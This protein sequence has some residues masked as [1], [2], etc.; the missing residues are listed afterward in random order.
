MGVLKRGRAIRRGAIA[1]LAVVFM[2]VLL[3][4]T[5]CSV[6]LTW[7]ILTQS[8]LRNVADAAALAGAN[9]LID[10]HVLYHLPNQTSAQKDALLKAA[11]AEARA[12]AKLYT[13]F[14]G[15]GDK[16]TLTLRDE[17][18]EFGYL[19]RANKYT[20]LPNYTGYPNTITV[21]IRRDSNA[22][23]PL[24]LYFAR[25]FARS[26]IELAAESAA[27]IYTG[28]LDSFK[29]TSLTSIGALPVTY[30]V[31]HWDNFLATGLDPDGN[32]QL[33]ADGNPQLQVYP[34][35]KYKGNFGLISL[36]DNHIGAS[37]VRTWIDFGMSPTDVQSLI[38]HQL[39][40]L[41]AH[42]K[43]A[44]DWNGE[45]GFKAANVMDVNIYIGKSF[46][47]PL[48]E[49]KNA[50]ANSYEAGVGQ[51]SNYDFDIVAFVGITIMQPKNTNREVVVQPAAIVEPD[52]VFLTGTVMP[53]Q[54]PDKTSKLVTTFTTP[55]LS[56]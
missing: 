12:A 56:R 53:A 35:I 50:N 52:A 43:N 55:K 54:P 9:K 25:V 34:S 24:D 11:Q 8:E 14:N 28:S 49:P 17:D 3:A 5:A 13:S 36:D 41:S 48:Y 51:G 16:A 32:K 18:I 19:D 20:P 21:K 15:A 47:I 38:D 10:N 42:P 26:S 46:I 2:I 23:Q 7:I 30:D 31:H 29:S 22:N 4:A 1:P 27:T 6:D 40:P 39:I 33:A 44:W 45:N 37:T